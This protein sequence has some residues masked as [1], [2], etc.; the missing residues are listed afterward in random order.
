MVAD[1]LSGNQRQLGP[2]RA[3]S[4]LSGG[5]SAFKPSE[6]VEV[7]MLESDG[8]DY[9]RAMRAIAV[10]EDEREMEKVD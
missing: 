4:A 8:G 3:E 10:P 6:G 2:C 1:C 7:K 9:D 5:L